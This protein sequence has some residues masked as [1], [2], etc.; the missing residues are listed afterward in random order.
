M[1][2]DIV[3]R[4][5]IGIRRDQFERTGR[6]SFDP[7]MPLTEREMA[8]ARAAIA[9]VFDWM[10]EPGDEAIDAMCLIDDPHYIHLVVAKAAWQ[11]ALAIKRKEAMGE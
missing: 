7:A 3:K 2:M 6:G 11:K 1:S 9:E 5:A 8:D 10:E 4:V